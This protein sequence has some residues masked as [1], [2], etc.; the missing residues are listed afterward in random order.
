MLSSAFSCAVSSS[1]TATS[2][3][4]LGLN[5]KAD[6]LVCTY[7]YFRGVAILTTNRYVDIDDAFMSE[8]IY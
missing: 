5:P 2:N 1:Y 3:T 6:R 4:I 8:Y 7:R